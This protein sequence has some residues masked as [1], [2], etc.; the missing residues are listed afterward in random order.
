[1]MDTENESENKKVRYAQEMQRLQ[2]ELAKAS[3]AEQVL[4]LREWYHVIGVIYAGEAPMVG[5][6][7]YV[8]QH[9][10]HMLKV[11]SRQLLYAP[12]VVDAEEFLRLGHS[13][14]TRCSGK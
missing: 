11:Y 2:T 13:G 8:M 6:K 5:G 4:F 10:A 9:G 7:I 3:E 1:M 14:L 12:E